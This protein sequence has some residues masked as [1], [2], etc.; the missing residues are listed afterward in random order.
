MIFT[1][2]VG[3]VI[4]VQ[5]KDFELQYSNDCEADYVAFYDS[6]GEMFI[7]EKPIHMLFQVHNLFFIADCNNHFMIP[8]CDTPVKQR[9]GSMCWTTKP[10]VLQNVK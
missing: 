2:T 5:E 8:K 7:L 10:K 3:R 9:F 6:N 4:R 1:E